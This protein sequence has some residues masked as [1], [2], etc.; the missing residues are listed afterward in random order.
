M[1]KPFTTAPF[2]D[3]K[4]DPRD[5]IVIYITGEI[6][7]SFYYPSVEGQKTFGSRGFILQVE[8]ATESRPAT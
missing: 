4:N 3:H 5:I 1:P 7:P 2:F 6:K 8:T